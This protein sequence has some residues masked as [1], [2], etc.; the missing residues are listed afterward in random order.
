VITRD[1]TAAQIS[2]VCL[3]PSYRGSVDQ[4]LS[5]P[6]AA[7]VDFRTANLASTQLNGI[8]LQF[9]Q[10]LRLPRGLMSFGMS[11]TWMRHFTQ[12]ATSASPA[13]D[14]VGTVGYP[15]RVKLRGTVEWFEH[16]PDLPGFALA[17]N[18]VHKGRYIDVDRG[19][20]HV[21]SD[22]T[23]DLNASYQTQPDDTLLGNIEVSLN[24]ANVLNRRPAWIDREV[25]YDAQAT[26][27]QGR[28][29]LFMLQK[30]W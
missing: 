3:S 14:L 26:D 5:A 30:R 29:M 20:T 10:K 15:P 21:A 23:I 19:G 8:D 6:V 24:L 27:P 16:G 13:S 2:A 22:T 9:N 1:P 28:V 7:I 11:T 25:G 12:A 17:M 4:C 18:V